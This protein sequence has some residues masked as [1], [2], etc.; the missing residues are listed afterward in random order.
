MLDELIRKVY[1]LRYEAI[2]TPQNLLK[3]ASLNNYKHVKFSKG[4]SDGIIAEMECICD[5]Y[6]SRVFLYSFDNNERL[7]KI[8]TMEPSYEVLFDRDK[9]LAS[10]IE[11]YSEEQKSLISIAAG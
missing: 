2:V 5:D 4:Q 1:E 6:I 7:Q 10:L 11:S 3:N 8:E 9:E